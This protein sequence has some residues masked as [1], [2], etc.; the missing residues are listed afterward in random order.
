MEKRL[1]DGLYE[2]QMIRNQVTQLTGRVYLQGYTSNEDEY[3]A[4]MT[5]GVNVAKEFS[6]EPG[7]AL[8]AAQMDA[9]TSDIVWLVNQTVTLPDGTTQQVLA[10]VV[11]LAHTHANDLQPTGALIA[12]DDVEIH[13]TGSAINSGVIKGGSQTVISATDIVNRGG[14]IGSSGA[15]GT[16]VV[17]ATNDVVNA[18]GQITGNR[19]A[20]LAGHDIVNTTLVDKVGVGS[21]AGNS[22][23][24]QTLLGAQGTIA[25]TGDMI[26]AAGHDLNVHGANIS[27]G[28]NALIA[29]GHDINVDTVESQTS[30][31]VAKNANHHWEA[32]STLNE[33]S[34]I[35]ASGGL[36][37]QSGNDMTFKGAAV[38]AGSDMAVVAGGNLTA[39]TV[40]NTALY[41]NVATDDNTRK[42]VD[43]TYDEQAVG[44]TFKAGGN[45]TLAA[46]STDANK[47]NVTLTGSSLSTDTGAANIAATGNVAINE[48]RE[49]HDSYTATE[50]KRGSFVH[51]STTD[52][53][54]ASQANIGVASTVSG[55]TVNIRSGKD[56]TVQGSNVVGT[57]DVKLAATGNVNITTSQDTQS[58]QSDYEKREYGFLSG[59]NSLNQLDGGLQGYSIGT[60]KTTDAQQAT[61]VTNN[62]SM[63]GSLNGSLSVAS[64]SD[65]HVTGS[66]LHAGNDVNLAGKTVT[67]DAAKNTA[68]QNEQQSFSQTGITAGLSSPVIAA[69]QT[70]NQMRKDVQH[71]KGDVRL[72]ALAA[73]TTGLAGKNAY[74]AVASDP[75]HLGGVGVNVSLGTSHSNSSSTESSTTA[76]GSTVSAGHNVNIAAAGAGANSNINVTGSDIT[77]GN[78]ATLN[79]Q[80]NINL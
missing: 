61:Q 10:P 4:L 12:A 34:G 40:T 23:V 54:Q 15:N 9:L 55:D 5:N 26:V 41:N 31:S 70:A 45:G 71:T 21:S 33:T 19:V 65:L 63:V 36:A 50:S 49:E 39:T 6:L 32:N 24:S 57:N 52:Q 1:G 43:R 38:S 64:G 44:T 73:A 79:A 3:R 35:S 62:G 11:Y 25:S 7:M 76:A 2:E 74:D 56:L 16:T 29:A 72:N 80:G 46:V 75:S 27:A 28:G 47:G 69:V 17:S 42:E 20:V 58:T 77:A 22:K 37:M 13:A 68:T 66:T 59:L 14:K 48:A 53:M 51:G 67:I 78:N 30:Q 8:T 60:R 18:S